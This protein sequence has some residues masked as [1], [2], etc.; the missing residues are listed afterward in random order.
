MEAVEARRVIGGN[1][2]PKIAS[3]CGPIRIRY[4]RTLVR[5]MYESVTTS[6]P[7]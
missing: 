2:F 4:Q 5:W 6:Q 3:P 1:P 7:A